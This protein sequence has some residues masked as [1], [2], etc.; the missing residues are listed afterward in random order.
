MTNIMDPKRIVEAGYD[1]IA[2]HYL[3]SKDIDEPVTL[4]ALAAQANSLPEKAHVLDLGCGAGVPVSRWLAQR[5]AV[6]G[7]DLSTRQIELARQQVPNATFVQADMTAVDCSEATFDAAVAFYSIIHVPAIEQPSLIQAIYRWLRPGGLFLAT[8][9]MTAWEG[10]EQ[11]WEGWGAPMWWSHL[12]PGASLQLL[13]AAG[14]EIVSADPRTV[15]GETWLW[16]TARKPI[17][18]SG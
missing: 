7:V 13:E 8:W 17:P 12:G 2:E 3:A 16:V 6:T 4:A 18:S 14:F 5:Y 9:A 10:Q 15:G 11:D 1:R